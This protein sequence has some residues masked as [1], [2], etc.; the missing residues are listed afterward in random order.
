LSDDDL[1]RAFL[2]AWE[3]RDTEFILGCFSDDA[4]YHAM[5]L[6]PISGRDALRAWVGGFAGKPPGRLEIHH[7]V[8]ADGIVVTERTDHIVL[9]DRPVVLPICAVFEI[10]GG[11]ITHWREYFDLT[12]A[13]AAYES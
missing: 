11:L 13:R 1:V 10:A 5:P 3:R 9:N 6:T 12:I 2:G 7:L 4:V 8:S